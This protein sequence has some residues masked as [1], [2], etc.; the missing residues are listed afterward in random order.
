M[1]KAAKENLGRPGLGDAI[2]LATARALGAKLLSG[3]SHF[4]GMQET[5]WLE[6]QQPS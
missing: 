6:D 2:L 1:A 5:I 3:D 4:K